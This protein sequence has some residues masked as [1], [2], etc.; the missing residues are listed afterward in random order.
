[1]GNHRNVVH[2]QL[3]RMR[4]NGVTSLRLIVWHMTDPRRQIWGPVSSAGG[5]LAEPYRTNLTRY[6]TEVRKFG[7]KRL[8]IAFGPRGPNNPRETVY[9]PGKFDENWRFLQDVRSIVKAHGPR[10]THFDLLNEGAPSSY[11][12]RSRFTR[13]SRYVANMYRHYVNRFGRSDVTV[14]VITPRTPVDKGRRLQN[15]IN[16]FNSTGLGQPRWYELHIGY[17]YGEAIQGLRDTDSVLNAKRL[18]QPIVVGETAYSDRGVASALKRFKRS[19][20]RRIGEVLQWYLRHTKKCN[21]PPP[22]SARRYRKELVSL[23]RS[24]RS[25]G[26]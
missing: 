16:I 14:S 22:Y 9:Q 7:F 23:P 15:L 17:N 12:P 13:V 4:R 10:S 2:R 8:T 25:R 11:A 19:S 3:Y 20:S 18:S 1:M 21:V 6:V 5:R 24:G 26:R